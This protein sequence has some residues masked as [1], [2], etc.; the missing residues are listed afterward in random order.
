MVRLPNAQ[1]AQL[2]TFVKLQMQSLTSAKMAT[3]LHFQ[4]QYSAQESELEAEL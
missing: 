2:D 1:S 4:A 3:P